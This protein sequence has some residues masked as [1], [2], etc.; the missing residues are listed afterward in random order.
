MTTATRTMAPAPSDSAPHARS[1]RVDTKSARRRLVSYASLRALSDDLGL[2]EASHRA[3]TLTRLGNHDPGPIFEHLA[4]AMTR[5]FDGFGVTAPL[6]LRWIGPLVKK[7]TLAKP[8]K[9]GFNLRPDIEKFAWDD[10]VSFDDGLKRLRE[11]IARA[12]VPGAAPNSAH[13]FFGVL[14]PQ[15]WQ[16]YY[17]RHAELHMSFLKP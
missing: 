15:E 7:S 9:P 17:L 4:S 13:P 12:Q 6:W 16:V 14:T 1:Q 8:F 3:G 2:I 11:Q 5:S 10:T